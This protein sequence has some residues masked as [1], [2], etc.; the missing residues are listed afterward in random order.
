MHD[1]EYRFKR[2]WRQDQRPGPSSQQPL[3]PC[4]GY[5]REHGEYRYCVTGRQRQSNAEVWLASA[6]GEL[7]GRPVRHV[8]SAVP[9]IGRDGGP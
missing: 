2:W 6:V 4:G 1:C 5:Y 3:R 9:L 8:T 7:G